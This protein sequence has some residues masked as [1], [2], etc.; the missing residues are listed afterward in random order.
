MKFL[1]Q[2]GLSYLWSKMKGSFIRTVNGAGPDANGN[3]AITAGLPDTPEEYSFTAGQAGT[4]LDTETSK[5]Y[6]YGNLVFCTLR[7]TIKSNITA[8]NSGL[9]ARFPTEL[10]PQGTLYAIAPQANATLDSSKTPKHF[11]FTVG[12]GVVRSLPGSYPYQNICEADEAYCLT[13]MWPIKPP[14]E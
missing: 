13:M 12:N 5:L 1:D 11:A 9:L 3:V 8:F 10:S 2:T 6:K 7:F 14:E 4:T